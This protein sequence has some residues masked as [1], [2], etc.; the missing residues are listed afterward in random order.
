MGLF[1]HGVFCYNLASHE[2]ETGYTSWNRKKG[3]SEMPVKYHCPGC[4]KRFVDWGAEKLGYK[5]PDCGDVELIRVGQAGDAKPAKRPSLKRARK[6]K[7][8]PPVEALSFEEEDSEPGKD[9]DGLAD[10]AKPAEID[11]DSDD[12]D[13]QSDDSDQPGKPDADEK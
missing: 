4:S 8:P 9:I 1:S 10:D 12:S 7:P 11:L 3:S 13:K 5:C 2:E 6:K